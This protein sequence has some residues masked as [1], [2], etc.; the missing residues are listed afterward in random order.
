M[1]SPWGGVV[2]VVTV[3]A[4]TCTS[5][6]VSL[7]GD[8]GTFDCRY[9]KTISGKYLGEIVRQALL[10]LIKDGA[11]FGGKLSDQFDKFEAFESKYVSQ[12][13]AR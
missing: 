10:P 12:I 13:E 4:L 1:W 5:V 8:C 7:S 9:E 6:V 3:G 2:G 11:L